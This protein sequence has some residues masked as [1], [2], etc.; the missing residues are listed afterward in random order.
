MGKDKYGMN[1]KEGR[2]KVYKVLLVI[3]MVLMLTAYVP[4]FSHSE[5]YRS[6]ESW[7]FMVYMAADNTLASYASDDL[8]EMMSIGSNKNLNIVVLYDSTENGDSA[9][10][11]IERG[12]RVT[13]EELGEVNMGSSS[14]L[15]YFLNWTMSRYHTDHYF[16]DLW[17]HGNFYGGIC[18]DHGDWLTLGEIRQALQK[19]EEERGKIIDVVGMDACRMGIMEVFYSLRDVTHYAVASEKDEPASGWP[20]DWVLEDMENKTPEQ[21]AHLVVDKMYQWAKEYFSKEGISTT[22]VAV[23]MSKLPH[24]VDVFNEDLKDALSVSSY[25]SQE[26]KNASNEAERYELHSNMDLYDFMVKLGQIDDYKLRK[27]SLDTR[28]LL[29][30]LAYYRVWDCPEPTNGVHAKNSH[31]IGIYFP[32]FSVASLYYST[33]FAKDTYWPK[34]LNAVLF[35]QIEK[36]Q[37]DATL[38]IEN[39]TMKI[40]YES[41]A[42]YVDMYILTNNSV[43]YSG[44]LPSSGEYEHD[45]DYGFYD[46]YIYAY[47]S[48]GNVVWTEKLHADYLKIIKIVGKFYLN[49]ELAQGAIITLNIGNCTYQTVQNES[50]FVFYL[51]YPTQINSNTTFH[52]MVKYG[53][54]EGNYTYKATSLKGNDTLYLTVRGYSPWTWQNIMVLTLIVISG[55]VIAALLLMRK[56]NITKIN[57]K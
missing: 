39:G 51:A 9:I 14:T 10:Y 11:Y 15:E 6:E 52:I 42:S 47:D 23:N 32:Q 30:G 43:F 2:M 57:E 20:Y 37:G 40:N 26:I 48:M 28:Q 27:L 46:V 38:E 53:M 44:Y 36:V 24:F 18:V 45:V 50:G 12:Q 17:D 5:E 1:L 33:E 25:Y 29:D 56:K 41:N 8:S 54:F 19:V 21:A 34:F 55:I 35:P 31:G 16:L 4:Q 13:L 7:T 49:D 22:M 3:A